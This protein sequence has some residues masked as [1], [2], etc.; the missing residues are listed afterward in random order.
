MFQF[1]GA[2][3]TS[4]F[5]ASFKFAN[6][7]LVFKQGFRNQKITIGQSASSLLSQKYLKSLFVALYFRIT[8]I[9]FFRNFN[10]VLEKLIVSN[11]VF[12]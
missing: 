9:I 2:M 7:T 8:L 10:V 3:C 11:I 12:F 5:P 6:V 4:K 1:N